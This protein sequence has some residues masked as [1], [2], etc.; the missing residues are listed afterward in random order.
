MEKI[1]PARLISPFEAVIV[2][3]PN[4]GKTIIECIIEKRKAD[5]KNH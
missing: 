3:G 1:V 4:K 2:A 5:A